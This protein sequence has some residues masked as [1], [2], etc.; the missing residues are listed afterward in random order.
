[1]FAE[2][3]NRNTIVY[4]AS[5]SSSAYAYHASPNCS[6]LSRST[7]DS[8]TLVTAV[9]SGYTA[10]SKCHPPEPNFEYE[11]VPRKT[12]SNVS[13]SN[14]PSYDSK[15]QTQPQPVSRTV[16]SSKSNSIKDIIACIEFIAMGGVIVAI[17][18]AKR[19]NK[20]RQPATKVKT[21]TFP[22]E[23]SETL[24]SKQDP[25]EIDRILVNIHLFFW[26][27]KRNRIGELEVIS[28]DTETFDFRYLGK[29]YRKVPYAAAR[30]KMYLSPDRVSKPFLT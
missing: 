21:N 25:I 3:D 14:K 8:F 27:R 30:G 6:A 13:S 19:R 18:F 5:G 16:S 23:T 4:Y 11:A 7:V 10:C 29:I 28:T 24:V 26:D 15:T 20:V 17:Q 9:E 1:M 2:T 22:L 12:N